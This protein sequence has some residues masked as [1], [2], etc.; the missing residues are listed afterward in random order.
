MA[1]QRV[2]STS[3]TGVSPVTIYPDSPDALFLD[4][5][6]YRKAAGVNIYQYASSNLLSSDESIYQSVVE[7]ETVSPSNVPRLEDIIIETN[8]TYL[9]ATGKSKARVIFK[10][11]NSNLQNVEGVDVAV[12]R[13]SSETGIA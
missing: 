8:E 4:P 13:P 11:N 9:D 7:S 3:I 12:Y 1:S 2:S 10:I 6:K 5:S